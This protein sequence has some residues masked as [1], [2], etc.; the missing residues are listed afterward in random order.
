MRFGSTVQLGML[1]RKHN[2]KSISFNPK[3][4][5]SFLNQRRSY[6]EEEL[7]DESRHAREAAEFGQVDIVRVSA[8]LLL[9]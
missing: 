8:S 1:E 3:S 2:L 6:Q 9:W 7:F 4:E 5:L